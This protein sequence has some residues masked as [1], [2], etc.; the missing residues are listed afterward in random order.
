MS[1]HDLRT[2]HTNELRTRIQWWHLRDLG[3]EHQKNFAQNNQTVG[4]PRKFRE[5]NDI[6][7]EQMCWFWEQTFGK[8][9]KHRSFH[10]M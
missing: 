4:P 3:V 6:Y 8:Q 1:T 2:E 7:K 5:T 10:I 9:Q